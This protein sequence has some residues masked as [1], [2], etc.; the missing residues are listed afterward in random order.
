MHEQDINAQIMNQPS[1]LSHLLPSS[2]RAAIIASSYWVLSISLTSESGS[3]AAFVGCL[4]SCYLIDATI[5]RPPLRD[6]RLPVLAVITIL[7]LCIGI[8]IGNLLTSSLM[9]GN[10]LGPLLT[11]ELGEVLQ[12][13]LFSAALTALLRALAHRTNYGRVLEILFVATAFVITLAAHRQGMIH[14]PFF[15]GDYA[16]TRGIDPSSILMAL[17]CAAVLSLAALLMIEQNHRRLPYHFTVLGIL[18]FSLLIYVQFFGLPSPRMT[19]AMGLTGQAR[20]SGSRADENPFRDGENNT[21]NMEAPV[22]IVLFRDDYEPQ[23]G[24]YYFRES[25]YTQ[26]NGT[27]LAVTGRAD[28]DEDLIDHFTPTR[29]EINEPL[30]MP[31][32]RQTV[33]TTIGLLAPHRTP[34]GLDTPIAY[35]NTPN[36]NNLRFKQVYDAYSMVPQFEFPDLIGRSAGDPDWTPAQ[37]QGYLE[38]PGDPRY[39]ELANTILQD[40]RPEF[41]DDPYAR[42]LAIKDYLDRNGIYSLKNEHAYAADPA[43]SFLFGDLTGYCMHFSFAAT[44]M[45]RSIGIPARVGMGYSVPASNRAG[46]SSLL[47]Q[48]INGHAWPEIYLDGIGWVIVDPAPARTLVDMSVDPQNSL[49]QLL[50]DMLRDEASFNEF[51]ASQMNSTFPIGTIARVFAALLLTMLLTAYVVKIYRLQAP[52]FA[53]PTTRYRLSYRATLDTLS[54]FGMRRRYGESREAFAR[55][56]GTMTPSFSTMTYSHLQSALGEPQHNDATQQ[57]QSVD[58]IAL[59]RR[60]RQEIGTHVPW[61]KHLL[62][63]INPFA[64]LRTH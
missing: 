30:P 13:F 32:R 21:N 7:I 1:A 12:W 46:G 36:P 56:L 18:C 51:L 28:L 2:L 55:R 11:Y 50:G 61:W 15:I 22:A 37:R 16:L 25:A 49:Q 17:G 24:A 47:I 20:E 29:A 39:Q 5:K 63:F 38:M 42:A 58:W 34:F 31:D 44:Y 40:L 43:A 53:Q 6:L 23:G 14:R 62:A 57:A 27:V 10:T 64:W 26:F 59:N 35:E 19:D 33:R 54:A 9:V 45:Y 8:F 3:I 48:A 52:H 60:I 41:A 4:F